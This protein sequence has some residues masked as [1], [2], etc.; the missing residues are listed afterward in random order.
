MQLTAYGAEHVVR[1]Q[2][3]L[4]LGDRSEP[5]PDI[6][7]VRG[8]MRDFS[9]EHP[10]TA[11]SVIEVSDST[12]E[13]DRVTKSSLY[14]KFG[15]PHYWVLNLRDR[16]LEIFQSPVADETAPFGWVYSERVVKLETESASLPGLSSE[17]IA[18]ADLLP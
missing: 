9:R 8:K 18:I 16:C 2:S 15:I 10:T 14:A 7:V 17:K 12:L 4:A 6:A 3:P 11:L 5:E 1:S 13:F